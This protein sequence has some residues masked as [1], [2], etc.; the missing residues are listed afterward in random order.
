M[1]QSDLGGHFL[2]IFGFQCIK[3]GYNTGGS[4]LLYTVKNFLTVFVLSVFNNLNHFVSRIVSIKLYR[5]LA[6][7][8]DI[9][10]VNF[11]SYH[12]GSLGISH[13]Y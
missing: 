6:T 9:L 2:G 10:L 3:T 13:D 11:S 1:E 8:H 4:T 5:C 12:R 7:F